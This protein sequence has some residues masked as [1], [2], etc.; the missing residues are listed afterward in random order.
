MHSKH[1]QRHLWTET[2]LQAL[3]RWGHM[4]NLG[5]GDAMLKH[6]KRKSRLFKAKNRLL[7]THF[8]SLGTPPTPLIW[9]IFLKKW[10]FLPLPY[11][12]PNRS[13]WVWSDVVKQSAKL[14]TSLLIGWKWKWWQVYC[15]VGKM[16]R[17]FRLDCAI[18]S[19]RLCLSFASVCAKSALNSVLARRAPVLMYSNF[20]K[21]A[22]PPL[23][24]KEG[25]ITEK[26]FPV[27]SESFFFYLF[28]LS[29]VHLGV[30]G[31]QRKVGISNVKK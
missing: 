28:W 2:K 13:E 21:Y 6:T 19:R 18:S 10:D 31:C 25:M 12:I 4:R 26:V 3:Q 5:F 30:N 17:C 29:H 27:F 22:P 1:I 23:H 9:E 24:V 20:R 11:F 16:Y 7:K 14:S 8:G 15:R